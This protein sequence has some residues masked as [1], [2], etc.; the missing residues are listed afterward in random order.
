MIATNLSHSQPSLFQLPRRLGAEAS[1]P[2]SGPYRLPTL[3]CF[4]PS[5]PPVFPPRPATGL[6]RHLTYMLA[7]PPH[8]CLSRPSVVL[9]GLRR[10][11]SAPRY[12]TTPCYL[13]S[14]EVPASSHPRCLLCKQPPNHSWTSSVGSLD[15]HHDPAESTALG[16]PMPIP[17]L[18]PRRRRPV[19]SCSETGAS[20]IDITGTNADGRRCR[21]TYHF[22]A[23][24]AAAAAGDRLEC[25]LGHCFGHR[26]LDFQ[27]IVLHLAQPNCCNQRHRRWS[28]S[29]YVQ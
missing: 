1:Y 22:G 16:S 26:E 29:D 8:L 10:P 25:A 3:P 2:G 20:T 18:Q 11:G 13:S 21:Q 28:Q 19:R 14:S 4:H 15:V 5:P 24:A 23:A 7:S 6:I 17:L 9:E 27:Y 12:Y